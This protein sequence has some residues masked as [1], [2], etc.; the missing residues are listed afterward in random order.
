MRTSVNKL[1]ILATAIAILSWCLKMAPHRLGFVASTILSCATAS[2][3]CISLWL[4][5]K[6]RK[7]VRH[8]DVVAAYTVVLLFIAFAVPVA[9]F[10]SLFLSGPAGNPELRREWLDSIKSQG[11]AIAVRE[12]R[13]IRVVFFDPEREEEHPCPNPA[14]AEEVTDLAK[15]CGLVVRDDVYG[16]LHISTFK[17]MS[18]KDIPLA[19]FGLMLTTAQ[20]SRDGIQFAFIVVASDKSTS[21]LIVGTKGKDDAKELYS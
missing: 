13:N 12:A 1:L 8:T 9:T 17:D 18:G 16:S 15:A 3:G 5:L 6:V 20:L 21:L 11:L 14:G 10:I 4:C 19:D 7:I 2:L